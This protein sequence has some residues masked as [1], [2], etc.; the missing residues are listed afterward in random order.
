MEVREL[1]SCLE[2]VQQIG[3]KVNVSFE[4]VK[5]NGHCT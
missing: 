3:R 1:M 2:V 4:D 5:L